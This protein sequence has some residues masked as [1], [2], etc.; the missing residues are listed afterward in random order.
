MTQDLNPQALDDAAF[1]AALEAFGDIH[2]LPIGPDEGHEVTR[3]IEAAI[4]AYLSSLPKPADEVAG[5]RE[6]QSEDDLADAI[7]MAA[8]SCPHTITAEEIVLRRSDKAPGNAL[9]QLG[10]RIRS[11]L[12][13]TEAEPVARDPR[14]IFLPGQ[15]GARLLAAAE[16]FMAEYEFDDGETAYHV[17]T[18]EER[19]YLLDAINGVFGDEEFSGILQTLT[20]VS[21]PK[22]AVWEGAQG[23]FTKDAAVAAKWRDS[24][25]VTVTP[26]YVSPPSPKPEMARLA[27][28]P[29][30][31]VLLRKSIERVK[32]MS[33]DEREAMLREQRESWVRGEMGMGETSVSAG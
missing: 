31:D 3:A 19:L 8:L 12:V 30:L 22:P 15:F 32:A 21:D 18:E 1:D 9:N 6:A 25:G 4:T 33:P 26:F 10:Q 29:E 7:R 14:P 2:D 28:D 20:P 17:P 23:A 16:R 13:A 5:V 24:F 27:D 11:A